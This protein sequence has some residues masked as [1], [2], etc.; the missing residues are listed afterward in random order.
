MKT[1]YLSK[2]ITDEDMQNLAN[3]F[4]THSQIK[5][6][7][8]E[9]IDIY[10]DDGKL[11]VR[12]RK[13]VIPLALSKQFY[14]AT[15][16][17]TN[18]AVT[19][20]RGNAT[21]SHKRNVYDNPRVKSAILGY[22]DRWAPKEK[23]QIRNATSKRI[24]QV[25][26]TRFVTE[27]PEKFKQTFPF[28]QQINKQYKLLLPTYFAKQY[29]KAKNTFFKIPK[30]AFTT[31][32]TNINFQTAIHKDKGDDVEGFGNLV[33]ISENYYKGG[34]TCLPQFGFGIDVREGDILFMDVHEWHGN[35]PIEGDN[36]VRMSVVCYLRTKVWER[37]RN[38]TLSFMEKHL[39]SIKKIKAMSKKRSQNNS[40]SN[41]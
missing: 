17:F 19:A 33:V 37:T 39:M 4:V 14:N 16:H 7:Y 20:N 12:F 30:T 21:G 25:R 38:K 41:K 32:T 15:Y 2:T 36:A 34:E 29:K 23:I 9:D 11:L 35:L 3:T 5:I 27:N 31:I 10:T 13:N 18:K 40:K 24:L 8:K 26:P 28:V 6:I 22:F 1:I